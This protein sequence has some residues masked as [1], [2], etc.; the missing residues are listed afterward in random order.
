[1]SL[2]FIFM[3]TRNDRTVADASRHLRTALDAGIRHIGFKDIGLP[4]EQLKSLNETIKSHGGTSYLEVVSLAPDSE[5]RSARA[6]VAI[7]VDHLMGG[8]HAEEVFPILSDTG[9]RYFP[10]A[11]RIAGHPSILEGSTEE[12]VDSAVSLT[13]LAGTHGVD[14]L[15]YRSKLDVTELISAVCRAVDKPVIV[16]GSIDC[17][18]RIDALRR[19]GAEGFT[20]GTAALDGVFPADARDLATQL[21]AITACC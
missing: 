13:S 16:A 19:S 2:R 1:M 7:G 5:I 20:I 6:A 17:P 11:G 18:E 12:I 9:I 14:L 21:K 8:T 10:F 3:M 4:F 15:A